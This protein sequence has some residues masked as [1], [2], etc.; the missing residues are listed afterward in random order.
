MFFL[1]YSLPG[2]ND[3]RCGGS[4]DSEGRAKSSVSSSSFGGRESCT[5]LRPSP[6]VV[7]RARNQHPPALSETN[8][9]ETE[10]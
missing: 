8:G 3:Y 7:M 9:Q 6:C 10:T 1:Q 2:G 5:C 4:G